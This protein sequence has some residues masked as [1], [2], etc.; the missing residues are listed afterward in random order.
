MQTLLDLC[1]A[2]QIT[3]TLFNAN[4]VHT[5]LHCDSKKP[6]AEVEISC[7]GTGQS[8]LIKL[9]K[10]QVSRPLPHRSNHTH[11]LTAPHHLIDLQEEPPRP[12]ALHIFH[13]ILEEKKNEALK[14][15]SYHRQERHSK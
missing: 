7:T 5:Y 6:D 3:V 14:V 15:L 8:N 4:T 2:I 10:D 11:L 13:S 9:A 1:S 12:Q